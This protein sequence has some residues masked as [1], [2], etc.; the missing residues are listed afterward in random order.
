[1][2]NLNNKRYDNEMLTSFFNFNTFLELS[3]NRIT[4][5]HMLKGLLKPSYQQNTYS[6]FCSL[7]ISLIYI[8]WTSVGFV[9]SASISWFPS[10]SFYRWNLGKHTNNMES[11]LSPADIQNIFDTMPCFIAVFI[12]ALG[13][14][15]EYWFKPLKIVFWF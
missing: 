13:R 2:D 1:M 3:L 7:N 6:F 11:S 8:Y 9:N 10:Y 5:T 4:P 14:Y 12:A 15:A